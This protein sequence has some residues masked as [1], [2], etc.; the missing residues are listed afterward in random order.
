MSN[1]YSHKKERK[2]NRAYKEYIRNCKKFWKENKW[3]R[4]SYD[5][6]PYEPPRNNLPWEYR[7]S[8]RAPHHWINTYME[9][10]FRQKNRKACNN[11]LK[12]DIDTDYPK[13]HKKP[14]IFYW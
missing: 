2:R 8:C 7:W 13:N 5:M 14:F 1:T 3:A 10:P 6:V 9:R 4:W 11:I 12:G